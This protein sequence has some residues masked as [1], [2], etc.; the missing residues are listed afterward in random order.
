M[1]EPRPPA[2][3]GQSLSHWTT[4]EVPLP[5]SLWLSLC[6]SIHIGYLSVCPQFPF[7]L[8]KYTG[9]IG[10]E[11]MCASS[12]NCVQHFVTPRAP[13]SMG[14]SI[15]GILQARILEEVPISFSR[16]SSQPVSPAWQTDSLPLSHLGS[17][18]PRP[19][20]PQYSL[21]CSSGFT[22]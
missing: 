12:P 1:I 22:L 18:R 2:W 5:L 9:H 17:P 21:V 4:R 8:Q 6:V 20:F 11:P 7:L 3:G 14:F 16:E 19:Q 10:L 15:C 13:L